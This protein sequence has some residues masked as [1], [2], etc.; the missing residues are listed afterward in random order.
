[1]SVPHVSS[2]GTMGESRPPPHWEKIQKGNLRLRQPRSLLVNMFFFFFFLSLHIKLD[3]FTQSFY[4]HL[5]LGT[6]S[7][8]V[9]PTANA[10]QQRRVWDGATRGIPFRVRD[11]FHGADNHTSFHS[12]LLPC[13]ICKTLLFPTTPPPSRSLHP[14]ATK[15]HTHSHT[16]AASS[17]FVLVSDLNDE[18]GKLLTMGDTLAVSGGL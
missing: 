2:R 11:Y 13:N 17:T 10:K 15:M 7:F 16:T 12:V 4:T 18:R 5:S 3:P 6:T 14:R 8:S 9:P 1:M